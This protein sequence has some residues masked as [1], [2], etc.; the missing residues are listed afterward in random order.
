M[1]A[2]CRDKP[3]DAI[4]VADV[5]ARAGVNRSTF[6]EHYQDKE[7]VLADGLQAMLSRVAPVETQWPADPDLTRP[8]R[9]LTDFLTH[10]SRN[11]DLYRHVLGGQNSAVVASR[12][13]D[14]V[15]SVITSALSRGI[16]TVRQ[17]I[18]TDILAPAVAGAALGMTRAWI[19]QDPPAPAHTAQRWMWIG[20]SALLREPAAAAHHVEPC[21]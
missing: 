14:Y 11:L 4:T 18:P 17:D 15:T 9:Q 5:C 19:T 2:L 20:L 13:T 6:Y 10:A 7:T 21:R 1:V 16:S 3:L 8:P 12:L